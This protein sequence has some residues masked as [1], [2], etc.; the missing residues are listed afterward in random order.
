V[1]DQEVWLDVA[2][3]LEHGRGIVDAY[4]VRTAER[5][6]VGNLLTFDEDIQSL[7]T[8]VCVAP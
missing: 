1:P 5:M 7:P 4:L 3:D 2:D 8:V 6:G